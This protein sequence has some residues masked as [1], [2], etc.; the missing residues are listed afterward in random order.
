M[1]ADGSTWGPTAFAENDLPHNEQG[2]FMPN[3]SIVRYALVVV[4]LFVLLGVT[5]AE[6]RALS[7]TYRV[8]GATFYDPPAGEPQNTHVYFE[9]TGS[10]ARDMYESMPVPPKTDECTGRHAA[11]KAIGQMQCNRYHSDNRHRCW[12]GIDV[13]TQAITRGVVC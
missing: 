8:G 9:L 1:P 7:G 6:R 11:V 10:S 3:T 5:A 12:F 4:M 13:R 2:G